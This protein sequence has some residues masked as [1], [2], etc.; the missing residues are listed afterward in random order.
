MV[1]AAAFVQAFVQRAFSFVTK[2][3]VPDVVGKGDRLDEVF[4]QPQSA[5][6]GPADLGHFQ[7]M[8]QAGAVMIVNAADEDLGLAKHAPKGGAMDDPLPVALEDGSKRVRL[9][10]VLPPPAV[11]AMH[12]VR[13]QPRIFVGKPVP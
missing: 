13:R 3:R 9:F 2:G 6:D 5:P 1:E 12:R 4:V 10:R 7:G 11:A 8:R